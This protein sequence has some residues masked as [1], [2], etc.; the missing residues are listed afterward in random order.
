VSNVTH[1][2]LTYSAGSSTQV[3]VIKP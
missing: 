1:S 3:T 2:T